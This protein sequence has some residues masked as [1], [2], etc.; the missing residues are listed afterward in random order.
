MYIAISTI[1]TKAPFKGVS[2]SI[3]PYGDLRNGCCSASVMRAPIDQR[4][5][6]RYCSTDDYDC[7]PAFLAKFLR[8]N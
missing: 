7:C 5:N 2:K 3:F 1:G 4:R 6:I 8:G